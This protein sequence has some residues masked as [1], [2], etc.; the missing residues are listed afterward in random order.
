V[1]DN[2]RDLTAAL[3]FALQTGTVLQVGEVFGEFFAGA[4]AKKLAETPLRV[5]LVA[6]PAKDD[7]LAKVRAEVEAARR[8]VELVWREVIKSGN[9]GAKDYGWPE[10]RSAVEHYQ[11]VVGARPPEAVL[12]ERLAKAL[13]GVEWSYRGV[14][15]DG[16]WPG[17][18]AECGRTHK[19]G[20]D[21]ACEVG[22]A[23]AEAARR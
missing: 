7:E 2:E 6:D 14:E 11:K 17:Q 19:E 18:C 10:A 13:R 1:S 5:M 22:H 4:V 15:G 9:A 16:T 12:A 3:M 21:D 8:V 23:L 20:H